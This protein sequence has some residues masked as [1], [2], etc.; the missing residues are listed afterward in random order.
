[1]IF[2][3]PRS[4]IFVPGNRPDRFDKACQAGADVTIIDLEDAVPYAEKAVA[5]AAIIAWLT[6]DKSVLIRINSADSVWFHDDLALCRL[7]GVAGVV[8]PKA[9]HVDDIA[10]VADAGAQMILPLIESAQGF[11]NVHAIAHA[12]GVQRL[13]FGSIDFQLDLGIEGDNE[14]LLYFRSQLVLV[15]RIAGLA[16]PVDGVSTAID[17]PE[18]VEADTVRARRLGFGAKLCIHPKQIA[19]IHAGFLP[20]PEELAWAQR[21]LEAAALADGAA[22]ALDGK[23][24]D[25]PVILKAEKILNA[26]AT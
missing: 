15:S 25:R 4:Y 5:R 7:P 2:S 18:S 23:M 11:W 21:V 3:I 20:N 19:P 24:I 14:E 12:P 8:L 10:M 6:A 16:A 9:E 1:M 17:A 13:L 22:V 26:S